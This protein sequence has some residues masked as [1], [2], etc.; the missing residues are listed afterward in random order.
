[1]YFSTYLA[2]V[3]RVLLP[4]SSTPTL[5]SA[6]Y[7]RLRDFTT[8]T[9]RK[10]LASQFNFTYPLE[11]EKNGYSVVLGSMRL[12]GGGRFLMLDAI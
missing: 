1:M 12:E 5:A 2:I 4:I 9:F 10:W 11:E 6:Q 8:W 7:E 3:Y